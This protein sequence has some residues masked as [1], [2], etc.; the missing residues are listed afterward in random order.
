MRACKIKFFRVHFKVSH[1]F[2]LY[3]PDIWILNV[4]LG[5]KTETSRTEQQQQENLQNIE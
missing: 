1:E 4:T 2:K 5:L 3:V